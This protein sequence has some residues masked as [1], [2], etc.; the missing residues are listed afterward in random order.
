MWFLGE[1]LK[2]FTS[3]AL[4]DFWNG[5]QFLHCQKVAIAVLSPPQTSKRV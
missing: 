5:G 1:G 4:A 3:G 2:K